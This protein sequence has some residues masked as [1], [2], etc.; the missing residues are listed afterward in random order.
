MFSRVTVYSRTSLLNSV[1]IVAFLKV[2]DFKPSGALSAAT[3]LK[4]IAK[5]VAEQ[6]TAEAD[7]KESAE[8]V[9]SA[10]V[11]K[12]RNADPEKRKKKLYDAMMR[13]G[14]SYS[15][16]ADAYSEDIWEE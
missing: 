8:N 14:F 1:S 6:I 11:R 9:M 2:I 7:S 3:P 10:L 15:D 5:S 12:Y 4:G 16:I 13:R